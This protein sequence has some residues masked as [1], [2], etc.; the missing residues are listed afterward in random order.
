MGHGLNTKGR[1]STVSFFRQTI[2]K[3]PSI[4]GSCEGINW[5]VCIV[6]VSQEA[7]LICRYGG[8]QKRMDS[9]GACTRLFCGWKAHH[10]CRIV[11]FW[12]LK[13]SVSMQNSITQEYVFNAK[14]TWNFKF[15]LTKCCCWLVWDHQRFVSDL[16]NEFLGDTTSDLVT[17]IP[18]TVAIDFDVTDSFEV[19]F[20]HSSTNDLLIGDCMIY[21]CFRELFF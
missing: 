10:R 4:F 6:D 19:I 1:Y 2:R 12:R 7:P 13:R 5:K 3:L 21:V 14:Q 9:V 17:F 8:S 18:Y 16:I 11:N 20:L 15:R